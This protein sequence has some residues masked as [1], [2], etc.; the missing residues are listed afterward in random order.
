MEEKEKN[1][2]RNFTVVSILLSFLHP[3]YQ[4]TKEGNKRKNCWLV[5]EGLVFSLVRRLREEKEGKRI[6]R[7][8]PRNRSGR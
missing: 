1:V 3:P 7:R 8:S 5:G 6:N 4:P 2:R